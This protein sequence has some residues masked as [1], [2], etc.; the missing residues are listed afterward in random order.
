MRKCKSCGCE[1]PAERLEVLPHTE[2]CV[3][4]SQ[5]RANLVYMVQDHKT[6]AYAVVIDANGPGAAERVRQARRAHRRGR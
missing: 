3:R 5:E 4:H 2:Y 1:I 6:A